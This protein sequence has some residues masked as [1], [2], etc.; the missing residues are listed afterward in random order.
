V[1]GGNGR[2][3]DGDAIGGLLATRQLKSDLRGAGVVTGG[4]PPLSA[5]DRS[6]FQQKLD[7]LVQRGLR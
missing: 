5:K 3:I 2:E 4:P 7:E 1:L 6:R